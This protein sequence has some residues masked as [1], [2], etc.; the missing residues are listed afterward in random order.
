MRGLRVDVA[1]AGLFPEYSRAQLTAALKAG[2]ILINEHAYKPKDKVKGEERVRLLSPIIPAIHTKALEPEPI[3]LEIVFEDEALLVVNKPAGLIVHPGAGQPNRTLVNG[4]LYHCPD[5]AQLPRA[6]IIHRL[7]QHTTGLLLVGKT[8]ATYNQLA[9]Q[10]RLRLIKR[11][12]LALVQ[13]RLSTPNTLTTFYGR[14]PKNRLKMA[15]RREGKEAITH[16][17]PISLF[18]HFTLLHLELLT[19]RTHQIRVHLAHL[20]HPIVGDPLYGKPPALPKSPHAVLTETLKNFKR[21]ALHA[22]TLAFEHPTTKEMITLTAPMPD[23][24][25]MLIEAVENHDVNPH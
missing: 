2:H 22:Y 11:H 1:L 17:R 20:K 21:Q 16:Y 19:G 9:E 25:R 13:G 23:D 18:P 8:P 12:Y 6:G 14:D 10:M 7:D 5:L 24:F 3:P 15:I 4:L